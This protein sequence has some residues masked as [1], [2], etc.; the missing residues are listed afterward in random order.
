MVY[1]I[2]TSKKAKLNNINHLFLL[3]SASLLGIQT[4]QRAITARTSA[5]P[6]KSDLNSNTGVIYILIELLRATPHNALFNIQIKL[7]KPLFTN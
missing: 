6:S 1:S 7:I 5:L 3:F 4:Q 2:I